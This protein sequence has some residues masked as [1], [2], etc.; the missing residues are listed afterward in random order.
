MPDFLLS[1]DRLGFRLLVFG[2]LALAWIL[3]GLLAGLPWQ[4][5]VLTEVGGLMPWAFL[6][7]M[8]LALDRRI[9]SRRPGAGGFL[10][11][12]FLGMVLVFIP[13]WLT[14]RTISLIWKCCESG[15]TRVP[16][17]R[18]RAD[19]DEPVR[20]LPQRALRLLPDPPRG[21]GHEAGAGPAAGGDRS[22]AARLGV[23]SATPASRCCSASSIP[24]SSST[25][26][27]RSRRCSIAIPP[28]PT[29]SWSACPTC[30]A[31]CST[32]PPG[33]P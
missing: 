26:C 11:A 25:R 16:V 3:Q 31:R 4:K 9:Q 33:K 2:G 10:G 7:P 27:R 29:G 13:Y 1:W 5:L 19:N 12:H 14:L 32:M 28:P 8:V 22:R 30:C 21:R 24:I 20:R 17:R 18:V 15:W 23:I 6:T